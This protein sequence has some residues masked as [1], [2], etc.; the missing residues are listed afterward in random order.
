VIKLHIVA[1]D[2]VTLQNPKGHPELDIQVLKIG[3]PIYDL[4]RNLRAD[5]HKLKTHPVSFLFSI[6]FFSYPGW[7]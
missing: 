4:Q 6:F 1:E 2:R 7:R 5:A 3:D